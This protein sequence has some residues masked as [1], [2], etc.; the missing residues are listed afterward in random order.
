M[1]KLGYF[2]RLFE[3][4][5]QSR[6]FYSP[7]VEYDE[8]T[9]AWY[10]QAI[11]EKFVP[12]LFRPKIAFSTS[13]IPRAY[14]LYKS[15]CCS[16]VGGLS[17]QKAHAH[18]REIVAD[19]GN[20]AHRQHTVVAKSIRAVKQL[21]G[22]FCWNLWRQ[23]DVQEVLQSRHRR[24]KRIPAFD[25]VCRCGRA[26]PCT[27]M[28]KVDAAQFF[29]QADLARGLE[30]IHLLLQRVQCSTKFN[31]DGISRFPR[32]PHILCKS[33]KRSDHRYWVVPF[34]RIRDFLSVTW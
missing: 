25:H 6:E 5:L 9:L 26:K 21:S 23:C 14:H 33:T 12:A 34:S 11:L 27:S 16:I 19:A 18:Y 20:V 1:S 2:W 29:K 24:L 7:I 30:R 17:C 22:E 31:A 8:H 4:Y 28:L 15:K 32:A 10:R 3:R 13:S